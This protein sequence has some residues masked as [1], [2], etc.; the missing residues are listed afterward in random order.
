MPVCFSP[1]PF[2]AVSFHRFPKTPGEGKAYSVVRIIERYIVFQH[3]Q[4]CSPA[5]ITL[6]LA[7]NLSNLIPALEALFPP[8]AERTFCQNIRQ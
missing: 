7:E 1:Q 2:G 4:F 5:S 6:S 8:E 3:K